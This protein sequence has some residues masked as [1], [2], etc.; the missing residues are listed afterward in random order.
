MPFT[1][2]RV[3]HH[4][5]CLTMGTSTSPVT[6]SEVA[7]RIRLAHPRK[8]KGAEV[9]H[10]DLI[11]VRKHLEALVRRGVAEHG[12]DRPNDTGR[13]SRQFVCLILPPA[14]LPDV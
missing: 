3:W 8:T 10:N 4:L 12:A 1:E 9:T 14:G 11:H 7:Q 13:R 5:A 2:V 6:P